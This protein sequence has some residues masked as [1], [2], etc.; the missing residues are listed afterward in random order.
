MTIVP[1]GVTAVTG[2]AVTMPCY[3]KVLVQPQLNNFQKMLLALHMFQK[4]QS[5]I[6]LPL[7]PC[8]DQK[9]RKATVIPCPSIFL[10]FIDIRIKQIIDNCCVITSIADIFSHYHAPSSKERGSK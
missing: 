7:S 1:K 8:R 6:L 3:P 9:Q 10:E 2:S 5:L 4:L